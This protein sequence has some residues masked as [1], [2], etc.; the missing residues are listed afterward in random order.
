MIRAG[1][2]KWPLS[3]PAPVLATSGSQ[4][5]V[6]KQVQSEHR[7]N[8]RKCVVIESTR[9]GP[10]K[11]NYKLKNIVI[12]TDCQNYRTSFQN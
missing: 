6:G 5:D 7:N 11:E 10:Q 2:R 3:A 4:G 9:V 1:L 8:L 12:V